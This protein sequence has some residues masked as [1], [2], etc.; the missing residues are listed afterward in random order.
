MN[1]AGRG[2]GPAGRSLR[3]RSAVPGRGGV[4]ARGRRRTR[5]GDTREP[6]ASVTREL[7]ATRVVEDQPLR[8]RL[9]V[10]CR[11]GNLPEG[12][13]AR[14]AAR[15][16]DSRLRRAETGQRPDRGALHASRSSRARRSQLVVR[17]ALNL[18]ARTVRSAAGPDEL[19]VLPRTERVR[20]SGGAVNAGGARGRALW[21]D[22]TSRRV[23]PRRAALLPGR[24]PR[25]EDP[26]AALARGAGLVERRF[27]RKPTA[28]RWCA[29]CTHRP[30]PTR[31]RAPGRCGARRRL[32]VPGLRP[33]YA[34]ALL[35]PGER[36]PR[37][38]GSDLAAWP[39]L[40]A[41]LALVVR[42]ASPR[43]IAASP[44][45]GAVVYVAARPP[46]AALEQGIGGSHGRPRRPRAMGRARPALRGDRCAD[47]WP[48]AAPTA[49]GTAA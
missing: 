23:R 8:M 13:A 45:P 10:R 43:L 42:S 4:R 40:H 2:A 49:A 31:R 22:G 21:T 30:E 26:L 47:T 14:S 20:P 18:A 11:R 29:R 37:P 34:V 33:L 9:E 28:G 38:L 19:L 5:M 32:A 35:L 36:R 12:E 27:L 7:S 17:D 6:G 15:A 44:A 16:S 1:R 3:R 39:A 25:V 41:R 24:R 48:T 46:R